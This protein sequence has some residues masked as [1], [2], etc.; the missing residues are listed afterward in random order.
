METEGNRIQLHILIRKF[1]ISG[2]RRTQFYEKSSRM[3]WAIY[4][5]EGTRLP[6]RYRR[7]LQDNIKVDVEQNN[8]RVWNGTVCL[9]RGAN[10]RILGT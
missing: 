3:R 8:E 9:R 7:T 6:G 2:L 10:C 5:A 1:T 4:V